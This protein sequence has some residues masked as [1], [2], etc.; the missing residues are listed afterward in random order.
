MNDFIKRFIINPQAAIEF[1]ESPLTFNGIEYIPRDDLAYFQ[2]IMCH[3]IPTFNAHNYGMTVKTLAR[4][5]ASAKD[6]LLN[7]R[8]LIVEN[9]EKIREDRIVGHIK[10]V[11]LP[12]DEWIENGM[13]T[14][15]LVPTEKATEGMP[16]F[17]LGCLYKRAKGVRKIIAEHIASGGKW[18]TSMECNFMWPDAGV[19]YQGEI[20]PLVDAPIELAEAVLPNPTSDKPPTYSHKG[21]KVCL[22][23]GGIDGKVEFVGGALTMYPADSK[24]NI[25]RMVAS[26]DEGV[27]LGASTK[28]LPDSAFLYVEN[29]GKK[30]EEGRTIPNT[31][32]HCPVYTAEG[33]VDISRLRNAMARFNQVTVA[34]DTIS[35]PELRSKLRKKLLPLARKHFPQGDFVKEHSEQITKITMKGGG[36]MDFVEMLKTLKLSLDELSQ[37]EGFQA[38]KESASKVREAQTGIYE[39]MDKCSAM[40]SQ[41][42]EDRAKAMVA[43]GYVPKDEHDKAVEEA[44]RAAGEVAVTEAKKLWDEERAEENRVTEVKAGRMSKLA[45]AEIKDIP[46]AL[47]AK[48][49]ALAADEDGDTAFDAMLT[50]FAER[51]T[52]VIEAKVELSDAVVGRILS[53]LGDSD[54]SFQR[55]LDL[56]TELVVAS[57]K[58]KE[59][60]ST[61]GDK[62]FIPPQKVAGSDDGD[63]PLG[64][65]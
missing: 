52:K 14:E 18:A 60:S 58:G 59:K 15:D 39:V 28:M 38:F 16:V 11:Y 17:A 36:I 49:E 10:D 9:D 53:T 63:K 33:E 35:A 34:T 4:S 55:E 56:W 2:Y 22:V 19:Y 29:T 12:I 5:A 6:Q 8:H 3:S 64:V 51:K 31:A 44:S 61:D 30:D 7:L 50:Q 21:K 25:L 42:A 1:A 27:E 48:V 47:K 65:C 62:K 37:T 45:E 26:I 46:D 40:L 43:D 32:R 41:M 24:A 54:E 57:K 23:G 20:L 13:L